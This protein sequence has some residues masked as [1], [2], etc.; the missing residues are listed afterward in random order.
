MSESDEVMLTTIDNPYNPFDEFDRW[1]QFDTS[2][3]Y[4]TCALLARV[5]TSSNELSEVDESNE[6][7]N[8][9]DDIIMYDPSQ[10]F[11]KIRRSENNSQQK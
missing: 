3:G 11:K 10:I 6:I 2:K 4:N 1:L 7:E 9:M 5:S 8:A